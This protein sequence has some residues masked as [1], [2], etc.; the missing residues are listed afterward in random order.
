MRADFP[1]TSLQ[2][3]IFLFRD[4][5]FQLL[6][7]FQTEEA[8]TCKVGVWVATVACQQPKSSFRAL[9]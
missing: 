1:H 8:K 7:F 2:L 3:A 9:A 4:S 5:L 6:G